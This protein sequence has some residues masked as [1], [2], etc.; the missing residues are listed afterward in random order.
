MK[1]KY[2]RKRKRGKGL[3]G[4]DWPKIYRNLQRFKKKNQKGGSL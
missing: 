3:L 1:K 4:S 2:R